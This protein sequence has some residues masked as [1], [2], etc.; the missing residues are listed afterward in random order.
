M[1]LAIFSFLLAVAAPF[2]HANA[3]L[4]VY[5]DRPTARVEIAAKKFTDTTG[6]SVTIVELG[7]GALL[8]K[9]QEEG[10]SSPA[11]VIFVKDMVYLAELAKDGYFQA[12]PA[13]LARGAV[14]DQLRDPQNLWSAVSMRARTIVY[15]AGR[16]EP[17][18]LSTYEALGDAKWTGRLCLRTGNGSYNEALIGSFVAQHGYA[19]AKAVVESWVKNLA[20]TPFPNDIAV[21]EAI[22]N[23]VCDV[24]VVNSYYLGM[25]LAKAPNLPVSIFFANQEERGTH[26][27][28]SGVGVASTSKQPELAAKFIEAL[29][30]DEVQLALSGAHFE[31]PAKRGLEPNTLIKDWG[32][33]KI[34]SRSWSESGAKAP[35]ARQIVKETGYL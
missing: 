2:S 7:Y 26:V 4:T 21:I 14:V 6:E 32:T 34:D 17:S 24:G 16:V 22:A 13:D 8:K 30:D 35:E 20:T 23:G 9:L 1:R 28:G 31:Y 33:F 10:A 19:G 25:T 11:D 15:G 29:Y 18:E 3:A 27:N 5:T 12:M